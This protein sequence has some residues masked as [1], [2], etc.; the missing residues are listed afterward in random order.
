MKEESVP[1][2]SPV[3]TRD[4]IPVHIW[5]NLDEKEEVYDTRLAGVSGVGLFRTEFMYLNN[6]YLFDSP[7]EQT[8][9]YREI[10]E[11]MDGRPVTFRLIDIGEDKTFFAPFY[12][13][14]NLAGDQTRGL[15]GIR[16]LL[17]NKNLL[18]SQITSI[19]RAM[20]ESHAA[21]GS[22]RIMIPMISRMEE[23]RD[24][25][26]YIEMVEQSLAR[27]Y[28][29]KITDVP[30]GLMIETPAACIMAEDFAREVDFFSL[31]TNDLTQ[32]TLAM[33]RMESEEKI[34]QFFQ[35]SVIRMIKLAIKNISIPVS[36]CGLMASVPEMIPL[37]IGLGVRNLS[38]SISSLHS[39]AKTVQACTLAECEA[40]ARDALLMRDASSLY[41]L[42]NIKDLG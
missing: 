17:E 25:I 1:I 40:I 12:K 23:I 27:E 11:G 13:Y 20:L 10:L 41:D 9:L 39:A 28:G 16:F 21:P 3:Y 19:I 14:L 37:L 35:P 34:E 8:I 33:P 7:E 6:P 38:V 26:R 31:G 4:D 36:V 22:C 32:F 2:A 42:I 29:K 15:R 24:T 5:V 30:V 18:K